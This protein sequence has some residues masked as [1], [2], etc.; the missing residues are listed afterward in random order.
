[1]KQTIFKFIC[2]AVFVL[3]A[4]LPV[5]AQETFYI[6]RNDGQF[7][8]F[9]NDEVDSIIYSKIALDSTLCDDYVVQEVYTADSLYRIPLAAIDSVGFVT[10]ETVYKSGVTDIAENLWQYVI[11][12][13]DSTLLLQSSTPSKLIPQKGDKLV[14]TEMTE[15]FP[16]GFAGEVS[17]V[18]TNTDGIFVS[19]VAV[20]LE[21]IFD[22]YYGVTTTNNPQT[23]SVYNSGR[24]TI[25]PGTFSLPTKWLGQL[26]A[27]CDLKDDY[28]ID[29]SFSFGMDVTPKFEV[30]AMVIIDRTHGTYYTISCIGDYHLSQNISF[31]GSLSYSR[32]FKIDIPQVPIPLCPFVKFYF[33]PG[34][35][36]QSE[37]QGGLNQ[38]WSQ[39]YRSVFLY[40][41]SSK[42]EEVLRPVNKMF[43]VGNSYSGEAMITGSLA[44]GA[45][46]ECGFAISD[47]KFT[48]VHL[49]AEGGYELE[50][51]AV[52]YKKEVNTALA[53]TAIYDRLKDSRISVN[54]FYGAS[55]EAEFM[56]K[57]T[58][59]FELPL[60]K[61]E[62]L[63]NVA[64]VPTFSGMKA[65][66]NE[67]D[68]TS[69]MVSATATGACFLPLRVGLLINDKNGNDIGRMYHGE[70][71]YINNTPYSHQFSG[72]EP[73]ET[74]SAHPIVHA[75]GI[76]MLASPSASFTLDKKEED[77]LRKALIQLY[78]ST[79]GDNWIRNDNWCSEKPITEWYGVKIHPEDDERIIITLF[80]NN[81]TGKIEQKFPEK[82]KFVIQVGG[83]KLDC[84][85]L[86]GC[87]TLRSLNC[88]NNPL[89]SL[90]ISTCT[91][92]VQLYCTKTLLTSL[93]V[94]GYTALKD[95]QCEDCQL[96]SL[97]ASGCTALEW[98]LCENNQLTSLNVSGC[99]ALEWLDCC[100]NQ[101][102]SLDASGCTALENLQCLNNPL[103]SLNL[104]GCTPLDHI[105]YEGCPLISLN[106]S[107]CTGLKRLYIREPLLT[108]LNVS[109]CTALESLDCI[110]DQLI[111]L[112]ASGCTA[113]EYLQCSYNQLTSLNVSGCTAL[114]SLQCHDNQLTSLNVSGCTALKSLQCHN[115]KISSV[116]PEW[117]SQ[118]ESFMHDIRYS[119]YDE[120]YA[121]KGY[122]WWY[123]GEPQKGYH[124]P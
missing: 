85:N 97:N 56:D 19:C 8:A 89:T 90:D 123:P 79:N 45:Y 29:A 9:F 27:S 15:T 101:L 30:S 103:A 23:R 114:K 72:L 92:L 14:Y 18:T 42:G 115:N 3:S 43:M 73:G 7:N 66:G 120:Y 61:K 37:V 99:T 6:Y 118:L 63:L 83:N 16:C 4:L 34:L 91:A 33:E 21:E 111:S 57:Y 55:A 116:I 110:N 50:S 87:R 80:D 25:A 108:S 51:N 31:S 93:D 48:N 76:E 102:T 28:A 62:N 26:S 69:A 49:R 67:Q 60:G 65:V 94:S 74:Y 54:K 119:Y 20:D 64:H 53:S 86:S 5:S 105:E 78:K 104:S 81:L 117:F 35:F 122:G 96:T 44:A 1:M 2:S 112:N 121:D 124:A 12:A 100:N 82:W 40:E 47:K 46:A 75:Y 13:T 88:S 59:S 41:Y 106:L 17:S 113:L 32:D 52:V 95:L 24:Q 107:G 58:L 68:K 39:H 38:T 22:T 77:E 71:H 109:G 36:V 10:P 11:T 70:K 98:L 84:I